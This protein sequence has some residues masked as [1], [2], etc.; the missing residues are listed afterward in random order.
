MFQDAFIR[1]VLHQRKF[2]AF[3][4]CLQLQIKFGFGPD[5]VTHLQLWV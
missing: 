5:L 4:A 1:M 2:R 3:L